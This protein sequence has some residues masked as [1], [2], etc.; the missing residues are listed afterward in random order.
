MKKL[1]AILFLCALTVAALAQGTGVGQLPAWDVVGNP[2]ASAGEPAAATITQMLDGAFCSTSTALLQRGASV[3]ACNNAAASTIK[4]NNGSGNSDL[5][6]PQAQALLFIQP[7]PGG[8]LTLQS[9]TPVM[10]STQSAQTAV[11]YAPYSSPYVPIYNGT[12]VGLYRFTSS[13]SDTVGLTLT[14]GSNWAANAV[15]DVYVFLNSGTVTL[16]TVTWTNTTTRATALANFGGL[17]TNGASA[18]CRTTNAATVTLA[19]NQGTYVGSFYTNGSTGTVDWIL[20]ASASGGT[21]GSLGVWNY[22]NRVLVVTAVTDS[23]A[24][25]NYAT[26]TIRQA[27]AS[28]GNQVKFLTG[29]AE[30]GITATVAASFTTTAAVGNSLFGVG[31][32]VTNAFTGPPFQ[33]GA[34]AANATP[35]SGSVTAQCAAPIGIYTIS[36]NEEGDGTHNQTLD[37]NSNNMLTVQVR[38]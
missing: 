34:S 33:G 1:G 25:Y 7:A 32:N 6:V 35:V 18:T 23:G 37:S 30:D 19:Q 8:R 22:Y 2:T 16:C 11:Y 3:W 38:M 27:R 4:G 20:G 13:N 24:T 17:L 12:Q 15:Y 14:L 9:A 5:T 28:T 26:A 31:C 36:A 21:A 10:T 29:A